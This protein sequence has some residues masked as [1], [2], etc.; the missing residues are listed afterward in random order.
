MTQPSY[1]RSKR[2]RQPARSETGSAMPLRRLDLTSLPRV[3]RADNEASDRYAPVERRWE[4]PWYDSELHDGRDGM[5]STA[6]GAK[7]WKQDHYSDSAL[8]SRRGGCAMHGI[9]VCDR[10]AT[11]TVVF[12]SENNAACHE[13]MREHPEVGPLDD[14]TS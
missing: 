9:D 6:L 12:P 13:W 5:A 1:D 8:I 2:V 4:C 11:Y 7:P 14:S 3:W 10:R